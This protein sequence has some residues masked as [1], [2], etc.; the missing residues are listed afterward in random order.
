VAR[1]VARLR[2]GTPVYLVTGWAHGIPLD[3]PRRKLVAAI[4]SKPINLPEFEELLLG[5]DAS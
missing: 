2:P 4:F 5:S 3:D 1:E